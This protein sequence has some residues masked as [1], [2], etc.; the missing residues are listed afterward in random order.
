M[1]LATSLILAGVPCR[2]NTF[3]ESKG[4]LILNIFRILIAGIRR[5]RDPIEHVK[6]LL[7]EH[8]WADATQLKKHDKQVWGVMNFRQI[9]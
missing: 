1:S 6:T 8:G 3:P 9:Y 7:Q 2:T 4:R 5:S